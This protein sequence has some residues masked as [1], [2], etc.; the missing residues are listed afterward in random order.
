M[1]WRLGV[2]IKAPCWLLGFEIFS[3]PS[4]SVGINQAW[5]MNERQEKFRRELGHLGSWQKRAQRI[6][7]QLERTE[8]AL[9]KRQEIPYFDGFTLDFW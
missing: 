7:R 5:Q 8:S 2:K 4:S 9:A 1:H 6:Q 3:S